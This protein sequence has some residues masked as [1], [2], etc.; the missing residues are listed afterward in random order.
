M[1]W[2]ELLGS[3]P[4]AGLSGWVPSPG[5]V[6]PKVEKPSVFVSYHHKGDQWYYNRFSDLFSENYDMFRDTSVDREIDSDDPEYQSRTIRQDYITGSSITVVLCGAETWKRKHVDWEIH[7]T[8]ERCHALLGIALPSAPRT[9][10]NK[11]VVPDRYYDN[12]VRGYARWMVWSESPGVMA[13]EIAL[14]LKHA[15]A[16][17]INNSRPQMRRNRS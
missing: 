8:L 13:S 5:F 10:D 9:Y 7:A 15:D 16:K 3:K 6:V 12:W 1:D 17:L 2:L 4:A 14:A 11:V